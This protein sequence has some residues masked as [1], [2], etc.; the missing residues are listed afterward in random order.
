MQTEVLL[1]ALLLVVQL[2][3]LEQMRL[4]VEQPGMMC[5]RRSKVKP[6]LK[7]LSLL[8]WSTEQCSTSELSHS[9]WLTIGHCIMSDPISLHSVL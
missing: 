5:L 8:N 4:A 9:A 1:Q 6:S 2:G 7:P 3:I